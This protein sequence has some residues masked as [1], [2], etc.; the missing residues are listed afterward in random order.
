MVPLTMMPSE[1][2]PRSDPNH[3]WRRKPKREVLQLHNELMKRLLQD[4]IRAR[5]WSPRQILRRCWQ[6]IR[7]Y[8]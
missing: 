8:V 1:S 7:L 4:M 5:P 3:S 6:S 2:L